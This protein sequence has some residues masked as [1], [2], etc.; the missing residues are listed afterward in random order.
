MGLFAK[1]YS[2]EELIKNLI[3]KGINNKN[4]INAVLNVDRS[5]F[6]NSQLK[7]VAY[8]DSALPI[9][10]NQTI[11]QPF[12][13]AYMTQI[14]DVFLGAKT[15]EIGTGSGYQSAI[16][17]ECGAKVF[18][19]ERIEDLHFNATEKFK[20]FNL[21]IKTKLGDGSLGWDEEKPFDRII[22][23]AASPNIPERLKEQL[24]I[25]GKMVVPVG[26]RES[27]K[28]LLITK[29]SPT[30]FDVLQTYDFKFVPLIGEDAWKE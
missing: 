8:K 30:K 14:L 25:D 23:T 7:G 10:C 2:K 5:D 3:K 24:A 28:M 6:I 11:S 26:D 15:L 16:L 27:Q 13:V 21:D 17:H 9:E 1:K 12:T 29:V 18:T 4:V 22:V 20:Q 19:V